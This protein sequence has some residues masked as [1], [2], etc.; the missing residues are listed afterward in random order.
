VGVKISPGVD[1]AE[2][3]SFDCEVEFI[4]LQGELK[5]AALWFGPLKTAHR[6]A[7]LLPGLHIFT[8]PGDSPAPRLPI[9]PPQTYLYEPDPA[10]LRAGLVTHLGETLSAAQLDPEIAYLTNTTKTPT[11]FARVWVVEDWFAFN[12]KKLRS[13]LRE[14]GIGRVTVKKRGSPITPE[15]LIQ[16][17]HLNGSGEERI[18]FLT[19]WDGKPIV[20]VALNS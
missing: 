3:S 1:L 15:E 4:S 7:T 9:S 16:A 11:P 13:Y 18:L 2:L 14:R 20:V 19:H 10:I 17:L 5:E 8:D 12:L 6:R